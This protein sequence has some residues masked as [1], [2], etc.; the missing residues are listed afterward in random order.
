MQSEPLVAHALLRSKM[1]I[2]PNI[3]RLLIQDWGPFPNLYL[4]STNELF[5]C[6]SNGNQKCKDALINRFNHI[7]H[8]EESLVFTPS[9]NIWRLHV[10][11]NE[12]AYRTL[13]IKLN[14]FSNHSLVPFH[15]KIYS[16]GTLPCV[17]SYFLFILLETTQVKIKMV[18]LRDIKQMWRDRP[19][20]TIRPMAEMS[21]A[22]NASHN[23]IL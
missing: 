8:N 15:S 10:H 14:V 2:R 21:T 17:A 5:D 16:I 6:Y 13:E 11:Y 3:A 18:N 22:F 20:L 12:T 1:S 9:N 19:N 7:I 4:M 23:S